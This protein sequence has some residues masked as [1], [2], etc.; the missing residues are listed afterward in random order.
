MAKL[1]RLGQM[2]GLLIMLDSTTEIWLLNHLATIKL[3]N[4]IHPYNYQIF[5]PPSAITSDIKPK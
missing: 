3:V 5:M 1:P 4:S 2:R